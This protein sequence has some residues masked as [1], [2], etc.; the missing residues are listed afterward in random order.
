MDKPDNTLL[1]IKGAIFKDKESDISVYA[2]LVNMFI[3][4]HL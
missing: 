1:T 2:K 4:C 3:D